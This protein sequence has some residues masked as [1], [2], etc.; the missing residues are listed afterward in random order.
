L[1]RWD[2]A[3]GKPTHR[4]AVTRD[5]VHALRFSPD[6]KT[7]AAAAHSE[8]VVVDNATW[9][10][11]LRMKKQVYDLAFCPK[12][13]RLAVATDTEVELCD[14]T[15]GKVEKTLARQPD[16]RRRRC[17]A[18]AGDGATL[19]TSDSHGRIRLWDVATG[20]EKL[21]QPDLVDAVT[22]LAFSADG[23]T[24]ASCFHDGRSQLFDARTGRPGRLLADRVPHAD[25]KHHHP[26]SLVFSRAGQ[27]LAMAN[28]GLEVRAWDAG[29]G[30][31]V[32]H[33]QAGD[34]SA[35]VDLAP[36]GKLLAGSL[37]ESMKLWSVA[38]DKPVRELTYAGPRGDKKSI[39]IGFGGPAFSPD[40]TLVAA[41]AVPWDRPASSLRFVEG[42]EPPPTSIQMWETVT[43]K[44][45][46]GDGLR[47]PRLYGT[48]QLV[49]FPDGK[50]LATSGDPI[51][52]WDVGARH[53]CRSFVHPPE[54][55]SGAMALSADGRW[56]AAACVL[57]GAGGAPRAW[58]HVV[59]VWET[60]SGQVVWRRA[61]HRGRIAAVAFAP[62][63]RSLASGSAD[64]TI[65]LWDL[66]PPADPG[67]PLAGVLSAKE[68]AGLWDALAGPDAAAAY[69]AIHQL[70]ARPDQA[71]ALLGDRLRPDPPV[72]VAEWMN[73]LQAK[74]FA[75]REKARQALLNL[76]REALPHLLGLDEKQLSLEGQRRRQQLLRELPE[77]PF[78]S[79]Q[80]RQLRAVAVLER[81]G[82]PAARRVLDAIAQ[83]RPGATQTEHAQAARARLADRR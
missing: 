51:L 83:G 44:P 45:V 46:A 43:G 55:H 74:E 57:H 28:L 39:A 30:K 41:V 40:G 14:P 6:G 23:A 35:H 69:A 24:L 10:E 31:E 56:L 29:T 15:T 61:S 78:T 54:S 50:T 70:A 4:L 3:A 20:A 16:F 11:R 67:K 42:P 47:D 73:E 25:L 65:V 27:V 68:L 8:V 34:G 26:S 62:D 60:A 76:G 21:A 59:C 81:V 33:W 18:L 7:I 72:P 36:D 80:L 49:F 64:A 37:S 63:G 82:G 48:R 22:G 79:Q 13:Q 52:L 77:R 71:V 19:A 1:L 58:Q 53:V 9:A 17:V 12:T 32:R 5:W 38:D 2:V 75:R 66:A